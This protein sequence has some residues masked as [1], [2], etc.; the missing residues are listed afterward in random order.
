VTGRL[1]IALL[2]VTAAG[3]AVATVSLLVLLT[4][5]EFDIAWGG[6]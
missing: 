5:S 2:A 6:R 4:D 3:L 1:A